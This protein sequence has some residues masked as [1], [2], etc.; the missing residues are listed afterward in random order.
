MDKRAKKEAGEANKEWNGSKRT[1][2]FCLTLN[3]AQDR[4]LE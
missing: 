3:E 2:D 4:E 1:E